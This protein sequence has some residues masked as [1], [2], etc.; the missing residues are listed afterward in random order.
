[1]VLIIILLIQSPLK[2][3][4][5]FVSIQYITVRKIFKSLKL[6]YLKYF[7]A[8]TTNAWARK[9]GSEL[10][11]KAKDDNEEEKMLKMAIAESIKSAEEHSRTKDSAW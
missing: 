5:H 4:Q 1:M 7:K 6:Y 11:A 3:L 2:L 10:F 8:V 9:K